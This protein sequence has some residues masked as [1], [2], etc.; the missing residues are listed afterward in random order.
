MIYDPPSKN[1]LT[2]CTWHAKE[3]AKSDDFLSSSRY[4]KIGSLFWICWSAG[5][6]QNNKS[7]LC[8]SNIKQTKNHLS[9]K[10][11]FSCKVHNAS[12]F[13]VK[14][15]SNNYGRKS[16]VQVGSH[17]YGAL[18]NEDRLCNKIEFLFLSLRHYITMTEIPKYCPKS[19]VQRFHLNPAWV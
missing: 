12:I 13:F 15:I 8:I 17:Y 6:I 5:Q 14:L 1:I 19:I 18:A 10:S 2:H 11:F 7:V 9:C 3:N 4:S 16:Y